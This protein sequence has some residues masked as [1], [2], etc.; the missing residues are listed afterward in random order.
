MGAP[1]SSL[2]SPSSPSDVASGEKRSVVPHRTLQGDRQVWLR[3]G[4]THPCSTWNWYRLCSSSQ[5][6][7]PDGVLTTVTPP[8]VD[9]PELLA[10]SPRQ[11]T[12]LSPPLMPT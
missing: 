2:S 1:S 4:E 6:F 7:A 3:L 8:L 5:E 11:P 10:I 12:L 9:P